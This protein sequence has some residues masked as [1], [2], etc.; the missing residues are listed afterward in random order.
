MRQADRDAMRRAIEL[1]R[2]ENAGRREQIDAKL[3]TESWESVG[4]F[5]SFHRQSHAL[6]LKPWEA[7]P[8]AS[9][10]VVHDRYGGRP[11]EVAL[12]QKMLALGVSV[13]EPDPLRAL[14][15]AEA[16]PK[17]AA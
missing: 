11:R 3:K 14:A 7:P 13:F 5:A 1:T 2:A 8:V 4:A 17:P 9:D 16:Q 10:D 15:E 6:R 12:R